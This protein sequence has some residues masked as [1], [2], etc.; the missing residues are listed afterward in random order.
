MTFMRAGIPQCELEC[1]DLGSLLEQN[2]YRL[3]DSR[4]LLDMVPFILRE[5][6]VRIISDWNAERRLVRL[7][8]SEKPKW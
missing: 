6:V 2:R 3:T 5:N 8:S 1:S 4:P 7:V